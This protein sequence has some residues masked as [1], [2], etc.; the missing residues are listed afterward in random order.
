MV[1]FMVR[2]EAA[3]LVSY[4]RAYA[5]G[6]LP[7]YFPPR[8]PFTPGLNG[9]GVIEEAGPGVYGLAAGQRVLLSGFATAAEN[10]PSPA[11]ALL[12][13]TADPRAHGL[14]DDWPDGTLAEY[15]L[16]PA[17]TV[18]PIPA[19]L[20]EVPAVR[21]APVIRGL[22]PYGG[23]LRG[24]LQPG[25][26]AIV[27]GATG[28]FG[29]A[30]V[31]VALAMGAAGVYAVGRNRTVLDRL[32][33]FPRV[34]AATTPGPAD[35]ALDMVGGAGSAEGTLATLDALRRGG[36]LVLMGSMTVPLPVDYVALMLAGKEILGNFMYPPDAPARL[37]QLAAAGLYDL[38]ALEVEAYPLGDLESA[39][40]SAAERGAPMVV[41][42]SA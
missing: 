38:D 39:M 32:A 24:R 31:Q 33:A 2:M 34:T 36:R 4:F 8:T 17:S 12:G 26:T 25:E 30:A 15:A 10:V 14:V 1:P 16:V 40:D 21:L 20:A 7:G 35:V 18:T 11:Q 5:E 41:V 28:A 23:F 42:G 27:H 29:Q 22:V 19:S 3:V 9:I 37:L 13:M 6:N